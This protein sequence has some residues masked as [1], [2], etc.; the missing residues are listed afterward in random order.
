MI[1]QPERYAE[2]T[3]TNEHGETWKLRI[4]VEQEIGYLSGDEL[5]DGN[6]LEIIGDELVDSDLI[7]SKAE[8]VWLDSVWR[9][10]VGRPFRA[11]LFNRV[12]TLGD[13]SA[14]DELKGLL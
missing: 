1:Y 7:L 10:V 4:D 12:M 2:R 8:L 5:D 9:E 11:S 3:F 6:V 13:M 14:I